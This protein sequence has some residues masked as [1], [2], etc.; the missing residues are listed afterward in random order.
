MMARCKDVVGY[1][2]L[3]LVL[4]VIS[5]IGMALGG[6]STVP[7]SEYDLVVQENTELRQRQAALQ[8]SLDES[9]SRYAAMVD[10]NQRLAGDLDRRR[11]DFE[12]MD[13]VT[14]GRRGTGEMVVG[15]AGDVLFDSGSATLKNDAKRT[16]DRIA[17]VLNSSYAANQ[18]RVEGYTDTDPIRRSKWETNRRL[19]AERA[20][21]VEEY[22]VS[23]GV[24]N[25]R[26]YSATFGETQPKGTKAQSRR[27]EIVL[28]APGS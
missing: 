17:Q 20:M 25:R 10:E 9:E 15:I 1:G 28:L 3:G 26:I 13:G 5:A 7:Q 18:I 19:G 2:R 4:G 27:V 22:L 8:R 16:L 12:G 14:T 6:C 24:D 23:K 21:A 11:G